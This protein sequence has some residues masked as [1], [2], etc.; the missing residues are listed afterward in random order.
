MHNPLCLRLVKI[1]PTSVNMKPARHEYIRYKN[2][3]LFK[4]LVDK[5]PESLGEKP[6]IKLKIFNSADLK[7]NQ[8]IPSAC[9]FFN[10]TDV[11]YMALD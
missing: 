4:A 9:M 7:S 5:Y 8:R 3:V 11:E 2:S 1:C 6:E 10:D